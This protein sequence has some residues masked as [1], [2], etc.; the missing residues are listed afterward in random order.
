M[1][2]VP[3]PQPTTLDG[4]TADEV[5]RERAALHVSD[6][7]LTLEHAI[8]ATKK[9]IKDIEKAGVDTNAELALKALLPE[10]QKQQKRLMQDTMFAGDN[11]RLI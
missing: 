2:A 5:A 7:L 9:G 8:A 10:L 4:R 1:S 6:V 3:K 11:L